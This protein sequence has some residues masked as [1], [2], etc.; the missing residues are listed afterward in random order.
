MSFEPVYEDVDEGGEPTQAVKSKLMEDALSPKTPLQ[1]ALL[2]VSGAKRFANTSYRSRWRKL[3]PKGSD[4]E[5]RLRI[6]WLEH[7]IQWG[8]GKR[9][10]PYTSVIA[11]AENKEAERLWIMSNKSKILRKKSV[12]EVKGMLEAKE[13]ELDALYNED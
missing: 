7:C 9:G 11:Y 12:G 10:M 6:A 5:A 1:T 3:E 4:P 13:K 8:R 2:A